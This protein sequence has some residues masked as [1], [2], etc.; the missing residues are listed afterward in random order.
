M[1]SI[2]W[3]PTTSTATTSKCICIHSYV[4]ICEYACMFTLPTVAA[5][6]CIA[7]VSDSL[8]LFESVCVFFYCKW[9]SASINSSAFCGCVYIYLH[10]NEIN[11]HVT[12]INGLWCPA[13]NQ[14]TN[15]NRLTNEFYVKSIEEHSLQECFLI[16][17]YFLHICTATAVLYVVQD[18]FDQ[19]AS[20]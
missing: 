2:K 15:K 8:C 12:W 16:L 13:M 5:V 17:F 7:G 20:T 11:F 4:Y 19:L 10:R 9:K 18:F 1:K 6:L 3:S 14:Q